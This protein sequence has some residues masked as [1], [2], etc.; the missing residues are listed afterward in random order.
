MARAW[1]RVGTGELFVDGKLVD[2]KSMEHTT[3]IMFPED[4]DLRCRPGYAHRRRS[5][6]SIGT[7]LPFKFT[8]KINRLT[9]DLGPVQLTE[10]EHKQMPAI[11]DRV[12]SAKD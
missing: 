11:K 8:G 6:S 9:F 3:P 1:A 12:A 5:C 7:T 10:E 2:K 4:E